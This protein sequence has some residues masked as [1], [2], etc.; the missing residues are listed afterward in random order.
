MKNLNLK[1][2]MMALAAMTAVLFI[3]CEKESDDSVEVDE[4]GLT[5]QINDFITPEILKEIEDLGM[6]INRGGN[7]PKDIAGSYVVEPDICVATNRPNDE[8]GPGHQFSTFYI[9]FS[10]QDNK[11]M[12]VTVASSQ[13]L[14]TGD[15]VGGFIVGDNSKFT[16]FAPMDNTLLL[17]EYQTVDIFSGTYTD[18]GIKD[19]YHSTFMLEGGGAQY[20]LLE[21][22]QGRVAYDSD[23]MS[24]RQQQSAPTFK[25]SVEGT[26]LSQSPPCHS[27]EGGKP[28]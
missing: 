28:L 14:M 9:T 6:P 15:G 23:G 18:E 10:E 22:G 27:S 5:P 4:N 2:I 24:N 19:F 12:T 7:P 26:A 8:Y 16:V 11:K 20:Y 21:N 3:S 25:S 13:S 1:V 17:H